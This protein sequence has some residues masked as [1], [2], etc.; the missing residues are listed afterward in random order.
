M[1]TKRNA[2]NPDK[3]FEIFDLSNKQITVQQALVIFK[4]KELLEPYDPLG[5]YDVTSFPFVDAVL[6]LLVQHNEI[7]G[8]RVVETPPNMDTRMQVPPNSVA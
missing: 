3:F 8:Y 4:K 6:K 7:S 5:V 2:A 1:S